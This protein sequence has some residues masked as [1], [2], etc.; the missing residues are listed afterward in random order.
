MLGG[1]ILLIVG[2]LAFGIHACVGYKKGKTD[3]DQGEQ[4][5]ASQ[6]NQGNVPSSPAKDGETDGKKD[7]NPMEQGNA[8]ISALIESYYKALGEKDIA[9][10][11]TYVDNLAPSDEPRIT[12]AKDY[13]EGYEVR[14]VYVKKGLTDDSYVVYASF[15][16][17]C[18]GID[19]KVPALSQFY[20]YKDSD[21]QW[22]IDASAF[23][24]AEISAYTDSLDSDED[25]KELY[26]DIKGQLESAQASDSALASFLDGLG[27]D[28]SDSAVTSE[29]TT[30]VVLD[31]CNVRAEANSDSEILGVLAVGEEV[32]KTG[33]EGDWTQVEY[34]GQT[35]YIYSNLLEEKT[36]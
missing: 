29:G 7:A 28:A 11:K 30:M 1:A 22:K 31:E 12:N 19:T 21:G 17:I 16:Y 27:Q 5:S 20:V 3:T 35:A 32:Q 34:E 33:T 13:I 24:D 26:S 36:E 4:Q 10:L 8:E 18:K 9:T 25:V 15:Y 14:D 6:E 23:E 2:A